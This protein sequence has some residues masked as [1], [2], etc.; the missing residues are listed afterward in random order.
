MSSTSSGPQR[1]TIYVCDP[2]AE[3]TK[4]ESALTQAGYDVIDV[5]RHRLVERVRLERP[6][7]VVLD[8]ADL[9]SLG[10]VAQIRATS[11]GEA[12]HLLFVAASGGPLRDAEDALMRDGSGLFLRPVDAS[13]L[14][15]KI[16]ALVGPGDVRRERN[17]SL[18]RQ[19]VQNTPDE[20]PSGRSLDAAM[21]PS[22]QGRHQ[23]VRAR[24]SLR[25]PLEHRSSTLHCSHGPWHLDH[26]SERGWWRCNALASELSIGNAMRTRCLCSESLDLV[27]FI[28]FEVTFKPEPL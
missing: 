7:A 1:P 27:L 28:G 15:R 13:A 9:A 2:S 14:V 24:A 25:E 17:A 23:C 22:V 20:L 5:P 26:P 10:V 16:E 8:V 21:V 12:I 18:L 11:G 3:A 6:A 19:P 4:T